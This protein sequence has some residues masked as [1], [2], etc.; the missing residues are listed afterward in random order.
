MAGAP[1]EVAA[2]SEL[3]ATI[4]AH[5]GLAGLVACLAHSPAKGWSALAEAMAASEAIELH[6][7]TPVASLEDD[8]QSVAVA[9]V[10]GEVF[11]ASAAIVAV[12]VNCLHTLRFKP[13]PPSTVR[14]AMGRN[15]GC[16]VKLVLLLEDV[17][18]H[19]L[20]VGHDPELPLRW[21]WI[22]GA[23]DNVASVVAF[24]WK[25]DSFDPDDREQVAQ[26]VMGYLP[27]ARLV[28]YAHHDWNADPWSNGTWLTV[29]A[30]APDLFEASHFELDG[31]IA[32]A[33][34]DISSEEAG[35]FEGALC[36]GADAASRICALLGCS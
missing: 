7:A 30:D 24:G 26:A 16:A 20:A 5:G 34:S 12:P 15:V 3:L 17:E 4:G 25:D 8:G 14:A 31:R 21:W 23:V 22:D 19:G 18:P 1:P 10:P 27:E 11:R 13:T 36:S 6:L 35:W 28:D 2:I 33:G 9:T 32:L 29:P